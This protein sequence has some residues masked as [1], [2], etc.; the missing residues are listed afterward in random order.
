MLSLG[1]K[2]KPIW[3]KFGAWAWGEARAQSLKNEK[4]AIVRFVKAQN[5]NI[6][7]LETSPRQ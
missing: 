7:S 3:Q 5:D 6:W 1:H 2:E 4:P